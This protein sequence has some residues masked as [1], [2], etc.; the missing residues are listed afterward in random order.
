MRIVCLTAYQPTLGAGPRYRVWQ[1]TSLLAHHGITLQFVP[2]A[3]PQLH[4]ILYQP[5][6]MLSKVR[7]ILQSLVRWLPKLNTTADAIIVQREATLIGPPIIETWLSR[8]YP[9]IFD[10]DDA[11]FLPRSKAH[12]GRVAQWA[13]PGNKTDTLLRLSSAVLA[14]NRYL[15]TYAR[16]HATN[17]HVLPTTVN[18]DQFQPITQTRHALPTLGWIGSH[19][20]TPYLA[21]IVPALQQ[22]AQSRRFRLLVVGAD[23]PISID[24]IECINRRWRLEDEIADFQ[25][26]DIG[27]YPVADDEWALGKCGLKAIQYGAV[28]IP[29]VCS[30][31]GVN[32]EVIQDGRTGLYARTHAEW[33]QAICRLLDDATLRQQMGQA[34][35][36]QV[37]EHYNMD[38]HGERLASIIK[39]TVCAASAVS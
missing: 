9:V 22:V 17:V 34:A 21:A 10:F 5:H 4:A 1:Y 24:G 15:A 28:G 31:I 39:D 32:A 13:R 11:I 19:S 8:R 6:H 36:Q 3:S 20:T 29:S 14:G 18:C 37:I 12:H 30:P 7:A 23:Q 26:L 38:T 35:R 25:S 33:V 27:L 16:H 2:F